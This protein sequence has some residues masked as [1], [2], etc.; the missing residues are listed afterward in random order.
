MIEDLYEI[1]QR[2]RRVLLIGIGSGTDIIGTIPTMVFLEDVLGKEV[3]LGSI[4]WDRLSIDPK[5]GPRTLDELVNVKRVSKYIGLLNGESITV[6]G[7][8]LSL[9]KAS[10]ILRREVVGVDITGGVN[11]LAKSLHQLATK[12]N[13]DLI[14]GIDSG[15]DV[16]ARGLEAG[17]STPLSE[18]VC[19]ASMIKSGVKSIVGVLG[20]GSDGELSLL[21]LI[22]NLSEIAKRGGVLGAIGMTKKAFT[23]MRKLIDE[24]PTEASKLPLL[25]SEGK[26]GFTI[27]REGRVVFLTYLSTIT[28]F[29]DAN[30][31]SKVSKPISSVLNTSSIDEANEE[32]NKLGLFTELDYERMAGRMLEKGIRLPPL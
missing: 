14:I 17:L 20:F 7:V 9:V 30:I 26:L 1:L 12:L 18:A 11:G 4:L 6:D 27:V 16:L 3:L 29:I 21:D 32:L 19:V 25:A 5:I 13:I 22:Y 28:I 2:S 8:E 23:I 31:L 24:I 10:R 15:G